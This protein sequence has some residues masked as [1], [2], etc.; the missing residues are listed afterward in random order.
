MLWTHWRCAPSAG[1]RAV[2]EMSVETPPEK[3]LK[4]RIL[5]T[6]RE[7]EKEELLFVAIVK[8]HG[9][10]KKE[11]NKEIAKDSNASIDDRA[12][13]GADAVDNK[14]DEAKHGTRPSRIIKNRNFRDINLKVDDPKLL[15]V[16]QASETLQGQEAEAKKEGNEG[17]QRLCDD[18]ATGG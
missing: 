5:E 11:S 18:N 9:A 6:N 13:A 8:R 12:K 14:A 15:N 17:Q 10:A 4:K 2:N 3:I 1:L 16:N 7:E